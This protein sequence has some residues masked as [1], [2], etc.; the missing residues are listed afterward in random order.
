MRD[1]S[2]SETLMAKEASEKL[3]AQA[4]RT[5]KHYQADNSRFSDNVF[6]D[7]IN[8]KDQKI[9]FCGVGEHHQNGIV[10][11]NN[12]I[13]DYDARTLLLHGMRTWPKILDEMFWTFSMKSIYERLNIL[14]IYHKVITHESILHGVNVEDIAVK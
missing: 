12:K 7:S 2:L 8:Q 5:V 10:E 13:L 3:M 11:N 4:G 6:I 9:T 1:L 14:Q